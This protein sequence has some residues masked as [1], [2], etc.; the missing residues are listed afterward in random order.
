MNRRELIE[1]VT[2]DIIINFLYYHRKEDE[3]LPPGEIEDAISCGEITVEE[4]ID[5]FAQELRSS[6]PVKL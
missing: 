5:L 1:V 6:L 2:K 4:I 3:D